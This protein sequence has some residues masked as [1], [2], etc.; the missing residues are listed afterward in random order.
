MPRRKSDTV[1][2]KLR[3]SRKLHEQLEQGRKASGSATLNGEMVRR[4]EE[5]FKQEDMKRFVTQ[6]VETTADTVFTRASHQLFFQAP[7]PNKDK[8]G[9]S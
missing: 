8:G 7:N 3:I 2:V 1:Q 5:S 4:L 6:V 9:K